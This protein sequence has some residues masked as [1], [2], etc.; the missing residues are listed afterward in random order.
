MA[1]LN[2]GPRSDES[3]MDFKWDNCQ[4][5]VEKDS[6][7]FQGAVN[8]PKYNTFAGHKRSAQEFESPTKPSLPA[9]RDPD[10][11]TYLFSSAK[12]A[13]RNPSFTTPQKS[14]ET[15]FS[16]G[17]DMSS[18]VNADTEDTPEL[19]SRSV[20]SKPNGAVV[21]F[22]GSK[23]E[24]KPSSQSL[25]SKSSRS[26]KGEIARKPY[27]DAMVRRV[28]KRR[29]RDADKDVQL[30]P[31]RSSNDSDSEERPSSSE[32]PSKNKPSSPPVQQMGFI[33]SVL[34]FIDAHPSLPNT[35]S[36]YVQ[37]L[38]NCFFAFCM[39]YVLYGVYS[40]IINDINERALVESSEIFAEMAACAHE[41]K[42]NRCDRDTR[43]PAM[44]TVCNN[45]EKCMKRDPLV[46]GRS[47]LSAGMF[48]EIFNGFIE[49]ISLKAIM[50]SLTVIIVCFAVNNL[51]FGLLRSKAHH[52]QQSQ[53]P[54]STPQHAPFHPQTPMDWQQ[55]FFTPY[56]NHMGMMGPGQG[57]YRVEAESPTKRL[58][59]R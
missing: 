21:Q 59:Y 24:K 12:S 48:A 51:T 33:P 34:T 5:P 28:E 11:Q 42:E 35:L 18:P 56:Q 3:P 57:G 8:L 41:F 23:L 44:E 50:V 26:G 49:P 1:R 53:P 39:M 17:P 20:S 32:G 6:P 47:R 31:R 30:A 40:T 4:G 37:F 15:D 52:H 43:V 14:I 27:T 36:Y 46:V 9:L 54:P 10:S 58:G 55:Q 13:L 45:W 16:S 7:F 19:P 2:S 29:R 38:L 25:F 22:A